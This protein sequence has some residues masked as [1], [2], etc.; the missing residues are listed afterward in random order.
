MNSPSDN[1]AVDAVIMFA[2]VMNSVYISSVLGIEMYDD[3]ITAFQQSALNV[4]QEYAL[5]VPEEYSEKLEYYVRGDEAFNILYGP[6]PSFNIDNTLALAF[7]LSR[8]WMLSPGNR[9]RILNDQEPFE[10]GVGIH[11][12]KVMVRNHPSARFSIKHGAS[13]AEGYA[14]NLAKRIESTSREGVSSKIMVSRNFH[15]AYLSVNPKTKCVFSEGKTV[16]LKG[17]LT[18]TQVFEIDVMSSF[19]LRES[20]VLKTVKREDLEVFEKL[21]AIKPGDFWLKVMLVNHYKRADPQ[22]A[23]NLCQEMIAKNPNFLFAYVTA[24]WIYQNMGRYSEAVKYYLR[25]E[26]LASNPHEAYYFLSECFFQMGNLQKA[27]EYVERSLFLQ[28]AINNYK[29][30]LEKITAAEQ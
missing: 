26:E 2:D 8:E 18:S 14:I 9:Q 29:I 30:Q 4:I 11:S 19:D 6:D 28:P 23:V 1:S 5:R 16:N 20:S 7:N 25:L 17:M 13:N 22:K 12:G 10:I 27:K 15:D 3:F 24:G 21:S